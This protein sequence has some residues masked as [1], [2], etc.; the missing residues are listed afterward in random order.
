M[1]DGIYP[2]LRIFNRLL[3]K[4]ENLPGFQIYISWNLRFDHLFELEIISK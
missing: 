3:Q 4:E 1:A 2:K